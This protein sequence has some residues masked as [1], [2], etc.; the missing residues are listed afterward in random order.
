LEIPYY[1]THISSQHIRSLTQ[2][3]FISEDDAKGLIKIGRRFKMEIFGR[4]PEDKRNS[5][6]KDTSHGLRSKAVVYSLKVTE[7]S[8]NAGIRKM[9]RE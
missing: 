2:V 9:R 3:K 7:P 6:T 4:S 1:I 5:L 8:L